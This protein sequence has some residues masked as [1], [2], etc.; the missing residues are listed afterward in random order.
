LIGCG[1][2]ANENGGATTTGHGE[3]LMKM[4]LAR[5]VVYNI[6]SELNAQVRF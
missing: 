3:P 2:Y 1:G 6:E 5:K 4:T